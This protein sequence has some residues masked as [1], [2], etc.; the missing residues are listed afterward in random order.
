[1][2]CTYVGPGT[3]WAPN[4]IVNPKALSGRDPNQELILDETQIQQAN[5]GDAI[6]LKGAMYTHGN[7][8]LHRSPSVEESGERRLLLRVDL[9]ESIWS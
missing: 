3:L 2:L 4:E 1:M 6:I 8:I 7:P 5:P 9:N